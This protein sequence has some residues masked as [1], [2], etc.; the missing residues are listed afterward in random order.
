M[1]DHHLPSSILEEEHPSKSSLSQLSLDLHP[2]LP[3][4]ARMEI[5]DHHHRQRTS[6]EDI[7]DDHPP[8]WMFLTHQSPIWTSRIIQHHHLGKSS[9]ISTWDRH[10]DLLSFIITIVV[11][12]HV[13]VIIHNYEKYP[14]KSSIHPWKI[15]TYIITISSEGSISI[16]KSKVW[17]NPWKQLIEVSSHPWRQL[18]H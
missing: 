16:I 14:S 13:M 2:H 15:R 9:P 18:I 5:S 12:F 7:I 17:T 11:N 10:G 8:S 4:S 1:D 6:L 3:S